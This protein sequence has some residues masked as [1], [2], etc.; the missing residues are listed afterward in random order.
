[1]QKDRAGVP[2]FIALLAS[3]I[4]CSLIF[5]ADVVVSIPPEVAVSDPPEVA[6]SDPPLPPLSE[7]R[8]SVPG[9][10][11]N[12]VVYQE[13][14]SQDS[15]LPTAPACAADPNALVQ[16]DEDLDYLIE[17]A[18]PGGTMTRQGPELAL[19]RL[20]PEF[21]RRLAI[22]IREARQAG[23][24]SAGIFSAYRPPAFG[25]GG[26]SDKF[27]SLHTYGLAVDMSGIGGPGTAEAKLWY[28]V[29]A[30]HGIVC[31]YGF[32]SRTEWNHCQPT[33]VKIIL[34]K[35]PLRDTVTA[36][37]PV[38]LETMFEAGNSVIDSPESAA[39]AMTPDHFERPA[40]APAPVAELQFRRRM[41]VVDAGKANWKKRLAKTEH[42]IKSRMAALKQEHRPRSSSAREHRAT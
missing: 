8:A 18:T 5:P 26:F 41:K 13:D 31:P 40:P 23:L 1:M 25:V 28:E 42:P 37:G 12:I 20:H 9:C 27:N 22:A 3:V 16:I 2:A 24:A 15:Q 21:A 10:D 4:T 35:N 32:E 38:S 17:T 7:A 30:K 19:G 6:I 39:A 14:Q 29:A 36:E 11:E 33:R 34:P